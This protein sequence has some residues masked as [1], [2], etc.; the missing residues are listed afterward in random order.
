MPRNLNKI[1]RPGLGL[2]RGWKVE[3]LAKLEHRKIFR[4]D[5]DS[6]GTYMEDSESEG[7]NQVGG[8][9][10]WW[11]RGWGGISEGGVV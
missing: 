8:G 11:G 3:E 10:M 4:A 6:N 1:V 9:G 2:S 7:E 5:W